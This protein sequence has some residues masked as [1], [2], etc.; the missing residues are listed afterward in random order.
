MD[1]TDLVGTTLHTVSRT[2]L[3]GMLLV[4][5][6]LILFLGSWRGALL[7]ALTIPLSLLVAFILMKV[8]DIPANLLS[9]GAIDFGILVDGAIVMMRRSSRNAKAVPKPN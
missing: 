1:R 8:T 9:L 6:V 3:E 2:L 4:L 5:L 7:V